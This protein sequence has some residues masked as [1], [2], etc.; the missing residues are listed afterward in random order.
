MSDTATAA[1]KREMT[2]EEK[3]VHWR[4][5][6]I[7][8]KLAGLPPEAVYMLILE[9]MC[10]TYVFAGRDEA[11]KQLAEIVFHQN[12]KH[13]E[14]AEALERLIPITKDAK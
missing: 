1:P 6:K 9:R 7:G 12:A 2:E 10:A 13:P 11:A 3:A 14:A 8:K 5:T 4:L